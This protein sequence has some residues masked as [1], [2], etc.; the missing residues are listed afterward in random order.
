MKPKF[1]SSWKSQNRILISTTKDVR[2]SLVGQL[3]LDKD[4]AL[5]TSLFA[6]EL[7]KGFKAKDCEQII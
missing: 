6:I 2:E 1:K 5:D 3:T 4:S 7:H